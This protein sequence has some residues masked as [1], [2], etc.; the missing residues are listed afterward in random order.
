[1]LLVLNHL[2]HDLP[3]MIK[4]LV[5]GLAQGRLIR[6]LKEVADDLAP[7]PVQTPEGEPDLS[8]PLKDLP[9]LLRQDEAGQVDK[10][11]RPEPGSRVGRA[12]GK[13]A[14]FRVKREGKQSPQVRVQRLQVGV[15][16]LEGESRTHSV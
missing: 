4:Q 11:A 15:G 13:I 12:G 14:K 9:D 3:E 1:L 10:H 2:P 6:E 7:L 16:V 8:Q 5:L